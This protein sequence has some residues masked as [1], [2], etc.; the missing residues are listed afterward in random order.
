MRKVFVIT[1]REY[2]AAVRTKAF[3]VTIV[4]MPV[5]MT[6]GVLAH[7]LLEGQVDTTDRTIAVVD[8]SGLLA[9]ALV[10]AAEKRNEEAVYEPK[11][12]KKIQP[13]YHIKIV[14][15]NNKDPQAQSLELS[16]L[17]R[18]NQIHA[19]LDIG[20]DAVFPPQAEAEAE[21]K[22]AKEGRVP[23]N[24]RIAYHAEGAALDPVRGWLRT[25]VNDAIRELRLK[26]ADLNPSTVAY[27]TQTAPVEPM[28]LVSIDEATGQVRQ[29][30]TST[31]LDVII[32]PIIIVMLM[33]LMITIGATPLI[34]SVIEEKMQRIAEVLLGSVTPFQLMMGKLIGSV[35]VAL[36]V[37]SV[38]VIGGLIAVQRM[39]LA[40]RVPYELLPWMGAYLVAAI[41]M[42]GS[43][44]VAIGAACNDLK[45]AQSLMLPVWIVVCLPLFVWMNVAREPLSSFSTG[46]SLVPFFTPMLMLIRQSMPETI[47]A[48][49]PWAGL[50]GVVIMTVILVWLAGRIFRIGILM[51]GKPPK[52]G[53][54]A[55]WAIR[56]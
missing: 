27:V 2:I 16:D 22:E 1:A 28:G 21:A 29:A 12:G 48:W 38:Y 20:P 26:K 8:R 44:F 30:Q 50:A 4:L 46:I 45:E 34:N 19:F 15:P 39:G 32:M 31:E 37:V 7:A 51:Q 49:Q 9:G 40:D 18:R 43:M 3:I 10:T 13:A 52:L 14:P 35:G 55:R 11:T 41:L 23:P 6:G 36:T 33:F 47:P 5:L 53:E 24:V 54:L 17:V 25:A 42:F 56:G